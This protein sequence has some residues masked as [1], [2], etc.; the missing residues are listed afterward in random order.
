LIARDAI[1]QRS[2]VSDQVKE[3]LVQDILEG[4]LKPGDKLAAEDQIAQEFKVSKV[5]VREALRTLESEGLIE[6]RR[7]LFGGS[8]VSQPSSDAMEQAF[9]NCYRFGAVSPKEMVAFR[10][11]VEPGFAALAAVNR[12]EEDLEKMREHI[13]AIEKSLSSGIIPNERI[14]E[15]H[16]LIAHACHNRLISAVSDALLDVFKEILSGVEFPLDRNRDHLEYDKEI[17]TYICDRDPEGARKSM[18]AHF[19]T[20][21]EI[22]ESSEEN[23][24]KGCEQ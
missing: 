5:T 14:L 18:I 12:T 11:I 21:A 17:Y 8:Y 3:A 19:K 15:F 2:R 24:D 13:S 20:L 9:S 7:G 16:S 23:K 6:K 10:K 22:V 1:S 4:R